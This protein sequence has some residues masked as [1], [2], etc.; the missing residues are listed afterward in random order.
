MQPEIEELLT[1]DGRVSSLS[2]LFVTGFL[3]PFVLVVGIKTSVLYFQIIISV[4]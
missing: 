4:L 2:I 1:F 3:M